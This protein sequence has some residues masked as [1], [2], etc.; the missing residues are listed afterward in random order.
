[1]YWHC[2]ITTDKTVDYKTSLDKE[3]KQTAYRIDIGIPLTTI[4]KKKNW[5][6]K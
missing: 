1:M 2:P 4:L 5:K 3:Q 6:S